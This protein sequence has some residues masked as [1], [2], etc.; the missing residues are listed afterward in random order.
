MLLSF[1]QHVRGLLQNPACLLQ[2]TRTLRRPVQRTRRTRRMQLS[3]C[4]RVT[5]LP[6]ALHDCCRRPGR[7]GGWCKDKQSLANAI[8]I[9]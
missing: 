5:G 1:C 2:A 4:D 9:L 3:S 7:C 8:V 6:Q